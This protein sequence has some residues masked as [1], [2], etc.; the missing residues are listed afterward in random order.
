MEMMLTVKE[1]GSERALDVLLAT[2]TETPVAAVAASLAD[3]AG[4]PRSQRVDLYIDGRRLASDDP[5]GRSGLR[6]GAIVGF[7]PQGTAAT[8]RN[9]PTQ[10]R[11]VGGPDAGG[12]VALQDG[13]IPVGRAAAG[14]IR[15]A[16]DGNASRRHALLHVRGGQVAV[17][18]LGS[19]NGTWVDGRRIASLTAVAAGQTIR[20]GDSLLTVDAAAAPQAA[21]A[22]DD[23]GTIAYNR[24]PRIV[25][26]RRVRRIALPRRPSTRER[27]GFPII[28]TLAPLV[29]GVALATILG[30]PEYLLFTL[31]SPVI[32]VGNYVSERRRG[33]RSSRAQEEEYRAALARANADLN[34]A[35]ADELRSRRALWPDPS[36]ILATA[37]T[38]LARLWERRPEDLDAMVLRVGVGDR[39]PETEVAPQAGEPPP[40]LPPMPAVPVTVAL[41]DAG[42][43]GIAGPRPRAQALARWLLAQAATLHSPRDLSVVLLA[44]D[45]GEA[46]WGW[47]RWLPHARPGTRGNCA[48]LVGNDME[49]VGARVSDLLALAD[50]RRRQRDE[51]GSRGVRRPP[52]VLVMIDGARALRSL[53]G[54]TTLLQEGPDLGIYSICL[55]EAASQLPG[56]CRALVAFAADDVRVAVTSSGEDEIGDVVADQVPRTWAED[57]A[58]ALSPLRDSSH[59]ANEAGVPDAVRLVELLKLEPPNP[60]GILALWKAA[61]RTTE[62]AL[63]VAAEGTLKLDLKRDGPHGLVAGTTGA[64]KSELLQT[65]I[66]SL[67]AVNAPDAL[68]FVLV[69]Y[70]GGSAFL[71]A[72]TLPHVVGMVTDLDAH[73]TERALAS[74]TAELKRREALL[75]AAEAVDIDGYWRSAELSQTPTEPLA[76]LVIVIDEFATLVEELP[77]FVR[78]LVGIAQRGRSLGVHLVLATQRPG[79]SVSPEIRAN[80]NLRIA[81]RMTDAAESSDV[82]GVPDAA[83][84]PRSL[85]GRA[86]V[87]TGHTSLT[88]FQAARVGGPRQSATT[89]GPTVVPLTWQALGRPLPRTSGGGGDGVETDLSALVEAVREASDQRGTAPPK[90]PW[91]PPLPERIQF[92][93]LRG[94]AADGSQS[95]PLGVQDLPDRQAQRVYGLDLEQG[96]HLLVVGSPRSG[97]STLLRTIAGAVGELTSA[98]DVHL[99][100]LDCGNGA[101]ACIEA[102]PHCGAV[103]KRNEVERAERLLGRLLDELSRRQQLL[104]DSG[105]ADVS[106]QRAAA[107]PGQRLPY[108]VLLL[109]R[110]EG[111]VTAFD[112]ID[113]GRLVSDL[114][115][116]LREGASA[117]LKVVITGD[118]SALTGRVANAVED[119]IALRLNDRS[120]FGLLGL[121]PRALPDA[122]P[123][124]RGFL[125]ESAVEVQFAVLAE[126]PTGAAQVAAMQ[127]VGRSAAAREPGLPVGQAPRPVALL[128]NRLSTRQLDSLLDGSHPRST[129]TAV[130]GVAGDRLEPL[131]VDFGR[132]GPGFLIAGAPR[133]GRSTA[134]M[135]I[136]RS[137][138]A[139]GTRIVVLAPR[140]SLLTELASQSGVLAIGAG[141]DVEGVELSAQ[142][143]TL[144]G[145]AVVCV[146]DVELLSDGPAA[147]A[148][149]AL[150]PGARDRGIAIVAAGSTADLG[151]FRGIASELKKSRAG[152]LLNPS[153]PADGEPL[154]FRVPRTALSPG[155]PGRALLYLNGGMTT[156]QMPALD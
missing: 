95:L 66:A 57:V 110:W 113:G 136:A 4:L 2:A 35:L 145:P 31:L 133:S 103:V 41:R 142:I 26:S 34:E 114:V 128:P 101:L 119:R 65:W 69:D 48:A 12:V 89:A 140:P 105:F 134:L 131:T 10:L 55:E 151:G 45:G 33:G 98:R 14:G 143:S 90:R 72:A 99:Y 38:P 53:P 88:A 40:P 96:G 150:L 100:G 144:E 46:A 28:T 106:E 6:P 83:Q 123:P 22:V 126:D 92:S 32:A 87:R 148:L 63:G 68:S 130:L 29:L 61:G 111:F 44:H 121:T 77:D 58:R 82:I 156:V 25:P 27:T 91:L 97:R 84:I 107:P 15:L 153:V 9:G 59:D 5:A 125:A 39:P 154:G 64:G 132:D 73:E 149:T 124:G 18:D 1:P 7:S 51:A 13:Q 52:D 138:L 37:T 79:G 129:L 120:D 135:T 117:G 30:R 147:S 19:T 23:D 11:I 108:I 70:K 67:A 93:E 20:V 152:L 86:Y 47:T 137:L 56:E 94:R 17:E 104:A 54:V 78:G 102:L 50:Q 81:L 60:A 155:P 146:D 139:C 74:L 118:R 24:P 3:A 112:E 80:T 127:E 76:R 36:E 75:T 109:D 141:R 116:L 115:R 85:P 62:A 42:V 43:L 71:E 8:T 49:T 16:H 21:V 122:I